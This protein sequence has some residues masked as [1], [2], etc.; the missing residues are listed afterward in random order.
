VRGRRSRLLAHRHRDGSVHVQDDGQEQ[1]CCDDD[2]AT[3]YRDC[4]DLY[5][6]PVTVGCALGQSGSSGSPC[7]PCAYKVGCFDV[8]LDAGLCRL[9]PNRRSETCPRAASSSNS[10]SAETNAVNNAQI[11]GPLGYR[12][13]MRVLTLGDGDFSF[14]L[15]I[16]RLILGS[17]RRGEEITR[18]GIESSSL[19]VATSYEAR[20]TLVKVY[21]SVTE[22]IAELETLGAMVLFEVDATA[23]FRATLL[24]LI[25]PRHEGDNGTGTTALLFDRIVWNF[26]CAAVEK[27]QDGQNREMDRNKDLVR[28]FVSNARRILEPQ[29][30]QIHMNHKTKVSAVPCADLKCLFCP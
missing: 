20:E 3:P 4:R 30:G 24:P 16:A 10:A 15:A 13:N 17:R 5:A 6:S 12:P 23:S 21:P 7:I 22:T 28:K 26:P 2:D 9:V 19:L 29:M 27:G 11:E 8:A 25:H 1:R 14:S 18:R